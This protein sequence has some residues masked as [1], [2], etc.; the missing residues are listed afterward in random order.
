ME[1]NNIQDS[2]CNSKYASIRQMDK[3]DEMLGRRFPFYPRT[4]IQAVHDGRTG[5]S[6]EAILAQ[7]NNIYV[8]Y[9][10]TAGRTRNI[11]PKE[12]R[13]KGIIISYVDM[14]GNAI[15]EKCVNDAQRDNFHWGLDVN[16][17]RVDELTL[18]GDISVSVKGTW[19]INGE[20]TGIAALGPK[21]DNGLTPW[22]KT[23]DNKLHFS[24]DN[25]TWEVCSDYIAAY[26]RFQDNKF[27]ISRNNKTWSDL[28]GEV[29]NSLSI[30]AYVTDKSQY[31][32]P[33]QGDMIMVGPT[34]ADDD[35]EHTKPIYH[36]NIYNA[37]GWVDHGPFQSINAGVVQELGDSETEVMSQKAVSESLNGAKVQSIYSTHIDW[38][39]GESNVITPLLFHLRKDESITLTVSNVDVTYNGSSPNSWA[40]ALSDGIDYISG[41]II[42]NSEG[43]KTYTATDDIDIK[44]LYVNVNSGIETLSLDIQVEGGKLVSQFRELQE[45][46]NNNTIDI[47]HVKDFTGTCETLYNLEKDATETVD[48][49]GNFKAGF[50]L[51][52]DVS[53]FDYIGTGNKNVNIRDVDDSNNILIV[54]YGKGNSIVILTKDT[55]HIRLILGYNDGAE[56]FSA[57]AKVLYGTAA[58]VL[59]NRN[60][61]N[62]LETENESLKNI[63]AG[64]KFT[65]SKSAP[66][67]TFYNDFKMGD[68][69]R[70]SVSNFS[71]TGTGSMAVYLND[72]TEY[73]YSLDFSSQNIADYTT[74]VILVR[75]CSYIRVGCSFIEGI[76]A[77][78]ADFDVLY[79]PNVTENTLKIESQRESGY[80]RKSLNYKGL[81][82]DERLV[83]S[84]PLKAGELLVL[85][86]S[87][88]KTNSSDKNINV[89]IDDNNNVIIQRY[90]GYASYTLEEDANEVSIRMFQNNA[91]NDFTC[92]VELLYGEEAEN[93]IQRQSVSPLL[94]AEEE[95]FSKQGTLIN[96]IYQQKAY[97]GYKKPFDKECLIKSLRI[98]SFDS[99]SNYIGKSYN[100]VI[101]TIDQRNW[102][103]PRIT[104]TSQI[105]QVNNAVILFDFSDETIVAKEGEVIF[106]EMTPTSE[107]RNDVLCGLSSET[108]DA[109]NEFMVTPNLNTALT[110]QS[111]SGC[112]NYELRTTPFKTIFVQK[113]EIESLQS[114]VNSL[115]NQLNTAGIYEDRVT[116]IKYQMSVS[117]GNIVLQSLD[118]KSMMVIGHSFVN[119]G[120]S[121]Q[122]DWY[123]DDSE[124]RAMAASINKHQWTSFIKDKLGLT[125]LKLQSGVDFERNYST[126][127]D[128]ASK[129]G[130][131]DVYDAICVYLCEN[132]VYNDTMQTSWEAMLNYLKSAAPKA[133]IFCTGSW[134]SNGKQQAIQAACENVSGVIYVNMLPIYTTANNGSVN[135]HRGDYYYGRESTYYP[136]GA[137]AGH[138]N[139]KGMLDIANTFLDYMGA[140]QIEDKTHNITL[141]QTS[142]GTI[143]TP[144]V[145]WLE[146]GIVTIRCTPDSGHSI[147]SVLVQ[148]SSG[149]LV[150]VTRRTNNYYD[151]ETERVYYT[152]TMPSEDVT[153]IPTWS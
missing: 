28:S 90:N 42:N 3:L 152:F 151:N 114:Q 95:V 91:G 145:E 92:D 86:V 147:R 59:S 47:T 51:A 79:T 105:K 49:Y 1:D 103:L 146:N 112:N 44:T 78:N 142:G 106:V 45:N 52:L 62:S 139:D 122:A 4:V 148:K 66:S 75:D 135:W 134:Q 80:W 100:F 123:L 69:V 121:P 23:I 74:Y 113:D 138:P 50:A 96:W 97:V 38:N 98:S 24:Y 126:D 81:V 20:D 71:Y 55:T 136:M 127:Y 36:L 63:I 144:N 141:N 140:E 82:N 25:E 15:T 14:Q 19:V 77:I 22:L 60:E 53:T 108:Y 39:N 73:V 72:G 27:Q 109:N 153:V 56:T 76:T 2:C 54:L 9:Q 8:Q 46:V 7:Y 18:S 119:Y 93:Y 102:L 83:F 107:T 11:V 85:V 43:T 137:P 41:L 130:V 84:Y 16:W 131:T 26:F 94:D 67:K 128:F 120:N 30:K 5:A 17:V 68:V 6:L 118:I 87:N 35:T 116:G 58:K 110:A 33:K 57:T 99:N 149:G 133:R 150:E 115:Q 48:I 12:M 143:G 37:G 61:I 65:I 34:Y 129:W 29:T 64:G 125:T 31:P 21:G 111:S 10:G 117:N 104:F 101:G 88:I 132:A 40:V 70:I 89:D 32:N 13:R 124:N